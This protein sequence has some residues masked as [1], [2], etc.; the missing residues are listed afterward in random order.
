MISLGRF[1]VR[2]SAVLEAFF[3]TLLWSTSWILI[4]FGLKDIPAITF[5]GLRFTIAFICLAPFVLRRRNFESMRTWN[6]SLWRRLILLG[7]TFVFITS[8]AQFLALSYMP[9]V[10]TNMIMSFTIFI[11]SFLGI[12]LLKESPTWLH[13]TGLGLYLVG[14][15]LYF[16]PMVLPRNE[17]TGMTI[18]GVCIFANAISSVLGR[19]IN[20]EKVVEPI[21]VTVIT[22]GIGG[23]MLLI[24][25]ILVQGLPKISLMSIGIVVWLGMVNSAFAYTLWNHSMRA[26]TAAE[27]SLINSAMLAQIAVLAWLFLGERPGERALIGLVFVAVGIFIVQLKPAAPK[28]IEDTQP[29]ISATLEPENKTL[30]P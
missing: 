17:I 20:R 29:V 12:I 22:V 21:L 5:A 19:S 18:M 11:V 10:T 7:F 28:I 13:W 1:S 14:V 9:A 15:V 4:K 16:Y 23:A 6:G 2:T 24:T 3:V 30:L 27:S 25:G 8:G 26:L